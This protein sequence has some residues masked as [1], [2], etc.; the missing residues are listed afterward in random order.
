[1]R[2]GLIINPIAGMGGMVGL[3]GTDTDDVLQEAIKRGARPLAQERTLMALR[4][5]GDLKGYEFFTAGGSMGEDVLRQCDARMTVVHRPPTRTTDKDTTESCSALLQAGIELL[6]FAGGDGTARDV[7]DVVG[8]KVPVIGIP[9]G[10]KMHSGVFANTPRDAGVLL[11]RVRVEGLSSR[12]TEVMDIDEDEFRHG[13]ISASLHGYMLT[14]EEPRLMQPFKLALGGGSE[15]EHKEAI[16][17]YFVGRMRPGTLYVLGPGTTVEMVG[18][19]LDVDKTLLGGALGADS[20]LVAKAVDEEDIWQALGRYEEARIVVSPIGAQGFIFGRGNQQIS[21]RVIRK[22]GVRNVVILATPH[23]MQETRTLHVDTGDQ[24]LDEV[25]R[26]YG[27][28]VIGYGKQ[29]VVPIA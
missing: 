11:R 23:K 14:P 6:M 10:V 3:K 2:V 20:R 15:D 21:P 22:V 1:V 7:M 19:R 24:E 13:R 16:A 27:K 25:L 29:L 18:R 12:P 8:E 4:A 17:E 28:V 26:G 9:S 5:A